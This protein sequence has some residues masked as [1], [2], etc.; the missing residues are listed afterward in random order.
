MSSYVE[1]AMAL[2][3]EGCNCAQ[4]VLCAYSER[5]G[6][7][8]RTAFRISEGFGGGIGGSHDGV[9]GAAAAA[10]MLAGLKNSSGSAADGLTKKDTYALIRSL[11][12]A[13]VSENGSSICREL[14][15]M[16][17]QRRMTCAERVA[18]ASR[19]VERFLLDDPA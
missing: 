16:N 15:E 5:F 19:I 11:S 18:S 2:H 6:I 9:C 10:Y 12:E 17:G 4:A 13:F 3:N 1:R 7:D 8:E 14:L